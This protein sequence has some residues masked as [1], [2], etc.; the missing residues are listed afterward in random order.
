MIFSPGIN[1]RLLQQGQ[2][3]FENILSILTFLGFLFFFVN[4]YSILKIFSSSL[5]V[6]T[7]IFFE[8]ISGLLIY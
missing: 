4:V 3:K 1:I 5:N 2:K 8:K 6:R 7:I